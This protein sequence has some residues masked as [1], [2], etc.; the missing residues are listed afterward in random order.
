[1][2]NWNRFNKTE[3]PSL[4]KFYSNLNLKNICKKE[5][6]HAQKVQKVFNIKN[7]GEY[8]DLYV[9]SDTTQLADTFEQFRN[10]CLKE[11]KLD[12]AYFCTTPDQLQKLV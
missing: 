4:D 11:Y 2:E 12:G 6:E 3:F 1:M 5:Y 10:V 8:H 7:L 9:Q